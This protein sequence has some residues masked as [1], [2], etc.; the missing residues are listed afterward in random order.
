MKLRC[1]DRIL[2]LSSPRVMGVLNATPDSF[3]DGGQHASLDAALFRA[4]EMVAQGAAIIDVGGES[5]RPGAAKVALQEELERVIPLIE[6]IAA[7]LDI[8]ISVDS[9]RPEVMLA[10]KAAG[11]HLINDVRALRCDGAISAAKQTDLPVCLMHMQGEPTTMQLSPGYG[12][13]LHD[14]QD[15]LGARM[16]ACVDAGISKDRLLIDPGFGFGKSLEHNYQLLAKLEDFKALD[17]PILIGLSRKS[18]IAAQLNNCSVSERLAGSLAGAVIAA[19]KGAHII[20][21]HDVKETVD[22][23]E[24]VRAAQQQQ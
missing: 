13:I 9:S 2:D 18:M 20:R 14:V 5:T 7:Q 1:A 23:L 24:I 8:S 15:F 21:V 19:M 16:Q 12:H 4:Q 10:A 17:V 6:A 22:A 11:A 3:S